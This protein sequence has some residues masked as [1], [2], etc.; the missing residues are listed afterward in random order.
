MKKK[1]SESFNCRSIIAVGAGGEHLHA[2]SARANLQKPVQ[3][4]FPGILL[5]ELLQEQL[6]ALVVRIKLQMRQPLQFLRA[7]LRDSTG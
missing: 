5:R 3:Q 7:Q 1:A 2:P 6:R 4:G